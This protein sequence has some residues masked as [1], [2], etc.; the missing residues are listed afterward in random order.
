MNQSPRLA[1]IAAALAGALSSMAQLPSSVDISMQHDEAN[2]MLRINLRANDLAFSSLLSNLVF[3][4]RWPESSTAS[5]AFGSSTWCPLPS[6]AFPMSGSAAVTPGNGFHYRTW[7]SIGLATLGS[8][9]DEGGC[10]QSLPADEWVEVYSIP[11][12]NEPGGTV[13]D[14]ADD[15]Y[16]S[17]NNRGFYVS[18]EGVNRTG[19]IFTFSTEAIAAAPVVAPSLQLQPN[20]ADVTVMLNG[21]VPVSGISRIRIIAS[22]GR[23]MIDQR[24]SRLPLSFEVSGLAIGIYNVTVEDASY[25][26]TLPLIIKR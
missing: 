22:D 5:L 3:T 20:P 16:A 10:S 12:N 23:V 26:R 24:A 9:E 15:T 6:V 7:T 21:P 8:I 19:G 25:V 14:I 13:Y 1:G 11:I 17:D 2:Q 4:V 18:L